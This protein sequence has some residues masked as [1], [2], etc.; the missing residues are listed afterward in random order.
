MYNG[1][2]KKASRLSFIVCWVLCVC[3]YLPHTS[4]VLN[5]VFNMVSERAIAGP[6]SIWVSHLCLWP[7]H[8]CIFA[9]FKE[10]LQQSFSHH[11]KVFWRRAALVLRRSSI[12]NPSIQKLVWRRA[13]MH[14]WRLISSCNFCR[15]ILHFWRAAENSVSKLFLK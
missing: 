5:M 13:A 7:V 15:L 8:I 1:K 6:A 14:I 4:C 3:V 11:S 2:N 9:A 12:Q 10:F